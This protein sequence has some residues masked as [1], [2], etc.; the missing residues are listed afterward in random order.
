MNFSTMIT[1]MLGLVIG[2]AIGLASFSG[3]VDFAALGIPQPGQESSDDD[4][5]GGA[6]NSSS[7]ESADQSE[8]VESDSADEKKAN[9]NDLAM[10]DRAEAYLKRYPGDRKKAIIFGGML[11][12]K[13]YYERAI[14]FYE[15]RLSRDSDD[16]DFWYGLGWACEQAKQ[17]EKAINSYERAYAENYRHIGALNNLA[18]VLATAPDESL[19]DGKRAVKLAKK[20]M[21]MA[22]PEAMWAADTLAA[23]FA[24]DGDFESATEL[25][26]L[27]VKKSVYKHQLDA[28]KRLDLYKQSKPYRLN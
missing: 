14:E 28:Q 1:V 16:P 22:G 27:V 12:K 7:V 19:R 21:R 25:Q 15:D 10:L 6:T 2:S 5:T 11:V 24:E 26:E 18:W 8:A 13:G 17:W 9:S 23:A 3:A 4:E 20:A